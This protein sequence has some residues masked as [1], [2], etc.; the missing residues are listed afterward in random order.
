MTEATAIKGQESKSLINLSP[1]K[2]NADEISRLVRSE[3]ILEMEAK[4]PHLK[5]C[6]FPCKRMRH[7]WHFR[8]ILHAH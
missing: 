8:G 6:I 3:K 7:P 4:Y 1:T 5:N 2:L